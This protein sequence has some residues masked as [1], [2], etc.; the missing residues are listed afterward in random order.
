[1]KIAIRGVVEPGNLEKERLVLRA[2]VDTDVGRFLVA[3]NAYVAEGSVSDEIKN[4]FW[5]P[6]QSVEAGNLVV[7]YTKSGENRIRVNKDE[8]KTH[9]LYL[10]LEQPIWSSDDA[11]VLI[12]IATW[13]MKKVS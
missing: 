13:Q 4:A 7:L 6:D 11:T 5:L 10:G 1:M 2:E 3:R 8:S 12:E 9:F